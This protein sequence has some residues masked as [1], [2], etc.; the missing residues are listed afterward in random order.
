M[1][2]DLPTVPDDKKNFFRLRL[3]RE[4][5]Q[6][7]QWKGLEELGVPVDRIEHDLILHGRLLFFSDDNYG[8]LL[9]KGTA[10]GNNLYNEPIMA[11]PIAQTTEPTTLNFS[12]KSIIYTYNQKD[13]VDLSSSCVLLDNMLFGESLLSIIDFYATRMAM[14]WMS[15]DTNLLWQNLPP[16][17]SVQDP[18][19]RLSIEKALSDIWAGKPVVIKDDSLKFTDETVK[20]GLVEVK[21]ILKELFD[22]YQE[23]YNDFKAQV[24]IQSTAVS[25]QSGVTESESTSNNQQV[26]TALQVMLSQ[27]QKFCKLVNQVYGLSLSVDI[28]Q[29]ESEGG[30]GDGEGH[31]RTEEPTQD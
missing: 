5:S 9:L 28:I 21:M 16:I 13:M 3:I 2:Y 31:N 24:G 27:R 25:K 26:R 14:T 18:N 6:L 1:A 15:F 23:L 17:I 4:V 12:E 7:F 29:D 30:E 20:V 11:R 8:H 10:H 19:T 22:A